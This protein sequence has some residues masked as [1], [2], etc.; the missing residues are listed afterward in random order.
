MPPVPSVPATKVIRA[1]QKVG[2]SLVRVSGSHH[3]V[4]HSD[5]RVVS[6]PVHGSKDMAKGTLR[7]ILTTI[8]MTV[9]EF[10]KLL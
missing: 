9:D 1:L 10:V 6:V 5:G 3:I 4:G 8:G 7:G 2:W